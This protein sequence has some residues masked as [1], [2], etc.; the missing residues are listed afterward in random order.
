[1]NGRDD[2]CPD[3]HTLHDFNPYINQG[4]E[5]EFGISF[6]FKG[7]NP[8]TKREQMPPKKEMGSLQSYECL[9][10]RGPTT[11]PDPYGTLKTITM[12]TKHLH[13]MG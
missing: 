6:P 11:Q 12:A 2:I 13:V 5:I 10:G 3:F 1:M 7:K 8:Q 9:F 4:V